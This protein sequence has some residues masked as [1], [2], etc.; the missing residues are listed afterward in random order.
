MKGKAVFAIFNTRTYGYEPIAR[1][2]M[3]QP[4]LTKAL[5]WGAVVMEATF[6]LALIAGYPGCLV[7]CRMGDFVS[8]DDE[9]RGDGFEFISRGVHCY[10][11]RRYLL[12]CYDAALLALG[13][14]RECPIEI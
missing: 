7:F 10:I 13:L 6:P 1:L 14:K 9:C 12:C 2:L 3:H 5:T 11:P 4:G 8:F